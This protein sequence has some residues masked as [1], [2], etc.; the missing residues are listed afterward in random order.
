MLFCPLI[1]TRD[2]GH[3]TAPY[4]LGWRTIGKLDHFHRI[5]QGTRRARQENMAK[6]VAAWSF[7]V[8]LNLSFAA[9]ANTEP[10]STFG[11]EADGSRQDGNLVAYSDSGLVPVDAP[12]GRAPSRLCGNGVKNAETE[13]CDDGNERS[14]DGCSSG[15]RIEPG[16]ACPTPGVPCVALLC[17]DG[18]V[19]ADEDCD[20]GNT[21]LGDGCSPSCRVEDGYKCP[22]GGNCSK[23]TCG[24]AIR[25]GT[26]QCD[27]GNL[28]P[29]DG[30]APDC[31]V[32]PKCVGG[33]CTSVCGDGLKFP[34]EACDDGNTRGGD[35]CSATCTLEAGFACAHARVSPPTQKNLWVAYRDFK[36]AGSSG[37]HPDFLAATFSDPAI[38]VVATG[39]VKPL[40]DAQGR[41]EFLSRRG[42]GS[43]DLIQDAVSFSS[44]FRDTP[45]SRKVVDT[46][47]LPRQPDGTYVFD[48]PMFFPL[49]SASA[50]WPERQLDGTGATRNF[51]FTSELRIPFTYRGNEALTFRGDDDVWVFVNGRLAVD[52]GG[53]KEA[54][55]GR[56]VL[57]AARAADLGLVIGG[58]YEFVVFQ[59]ER[60]PTQSSYRLTLNDFDRIVST[61]QSICGDGVKTANELCDEG[62][63]KNDGSYGRC[64]TD[65][66]RGPFCG[67][68]IVQAAEG[69]QCDSSSGCTADCRLVANGP[70]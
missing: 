52:L 23:T 22:G 4:Q 57:D 31:H 25:E 20:D 35:G 47:Q 45:L 43:V 61:C 42:S 29:F 46:L 36:A 1:S 44:W 37:G 9:C 38:N 50:A 58:F 56:V 6:R 2:R 53:V 48:S 39:L 67:D 27:D 65:C 21:K 5:A 64:T 7:V 24:D 16:Y 70:R 26:E 69:E 49:D 28:D 62:T 55:D 18:V 13:L 54:R 3:C 59:A 11:D 40:L 66:G 41:P 51:L 14:G 30:C 12:D 68:G 15:C 32:E 17:G 19:A 33:S 63:A 8:V 34:S 10:L 60:N